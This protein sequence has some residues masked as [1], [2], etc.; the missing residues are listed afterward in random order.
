MSPS[1]RNPGRARRGFGPSLPTVQKWYYPLNSA[2]AMTSSLSHVHK[3]LVGTSRDAQPGQDTRGHGG[4]DGKGTSTAGDADV[5][6]A[7]AL[8]HDPLQLTLLTRQCLGTSST[9]AAAGTEPSTPNVQ[10]EAASA[11]A[12]LEVMLHRRLKNDDGRGLGEGVDDVTVVSPVLWLTADTVTVSNDR[13]R[14]LSQHLHFPLRLFAGSLPTSDGVSAGVGAP[15]VTRTQ[16]SQPVAE[17]YAPPVELP[18]KRTWLRLEPVAVA[19]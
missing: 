15:H 13:W 8:R 12:T 5:D 11:T 19:A 1:T 2:A 14:R 9:Q 7:A 4:G 18:R 6:G 10:S 16:A 3:S 17:W